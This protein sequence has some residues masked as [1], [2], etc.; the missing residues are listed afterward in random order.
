MWNLSMLYHLGGL[1]NIL[2]LICCYSC[3]LDLLG[4]A[5]RLAENYC[6]LCVEDYVFEKEI[7]SMSVE[8]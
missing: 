3:N 2:L 4:F 8:H 1:R 6:S 7:F 5:S